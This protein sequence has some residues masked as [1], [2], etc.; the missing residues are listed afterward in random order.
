MNAIPTMPNPTTT[1]FFLLCT[2][3]SAASSAEESFGARLIAMPGEEFA[4]DIMVL[5][6][7]DRS[8]GR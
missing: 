2:G 3:A 1:I 8:C 6:F 5:L 7:C 4:H